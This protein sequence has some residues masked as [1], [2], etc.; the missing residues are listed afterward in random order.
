M[1]LKSVVTANLQIKLFSLLLA[2]LLW[3][4]IALETADELEIPLS[5]SYDSIPSG[6][7]VMA[8]RNPEP[9]LRIGGPRIL[10]LRQ[11]LKGVSV[12]FDFSGVQ[13][14]E[15]TLT[16]EESSLQLVQGVKLVHFPSMKVTIFR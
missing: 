7:T 1:N 5:V 12:H 3:L 2:A 14:G 8:D 16:G 4:F 15:L 6:F 11:K 13:A 10:L 9:L